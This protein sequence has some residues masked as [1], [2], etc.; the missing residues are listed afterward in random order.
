MKHLQL[1][2]QFITEKNHKIGPYK[3]NDKTPSEELY[4]MFHQAMAKQFASEDEREGY[5]E[6]DYEKAHKTIKK[7][8]LGRGHNPWRDKKTWAEDYVEDGDGD[9]DFDSRSKKYR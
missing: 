7:I 5:T 1:F 8:M 3:F 9:D 4:V 6:S 2:E